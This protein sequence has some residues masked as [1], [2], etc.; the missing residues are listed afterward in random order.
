MEQI[1]TDGVVLKRTFVGEK[2]A[3]IKILTQEAGLVSASVKG[4]KNMKSKLSA[5]SS[6][7]SFSD[8]VLKPNKDL[9]IV[10]Q[11][12][13]KEGFFGLSSNIERLSYAAYF[14]DLVVAFNPSAEDAKRIMPLLLNTLYLL[15]NSDKD[16]ELIK[17]VFELRLLCSL[18][19]SPELDECVACGENEKLSFFS[20]SQGGVVC[21]GCSAT[22]TVIITDD[23]LSA[24]RY[25]K[26]A[27][28]KKA[29]SFT[30]STGAKDEFGRCTESLIDSVLSH[31][32]NSLKYLK[33]ITG[34]M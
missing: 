28:N 20:A 21:T 27:D 1:K 23:T 10:S 7:F 22:D 15:S 6:V 8:F 17:C 29:F 2:D 12:I 13:Q 11:S 31:R 5:G 18:G 3:I 14:A 30:L 32:L 24:M 19:F 25:A 34:K 9:Y 16:M 4:I 26:D 33:Q